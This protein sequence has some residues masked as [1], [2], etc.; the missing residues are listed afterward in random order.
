M[1]S[2]NFEYFFKENFS[3]AYRF[4]YF[5]I[6]DSDEVYSE[7]H[8]LFIKTYRKSG[9]VTDPKVYLFRHAVRL[10]S[11][12]TV[13]FSDTAGENLRGLTRHQQIILGLRVLGE[14]S[15]EQVSSV[16]K[17]KEKDILREAGD[18]LKLI[19]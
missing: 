12:K 10:L 8:K 2:S 1:L 11:G 19:K 18:A 6:N 14:L 13:S 5:F 3:K 17:S 15:F 16:L 4:L 7:T 9:K